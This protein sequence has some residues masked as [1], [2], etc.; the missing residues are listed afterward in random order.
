M[1]TVDI[2]TDIKHKKADTI[3]PLDEVEAL[4][5]TLE[6]MDFKAAMSSLNTDNP[7]PKDDIEWIDLYFIKNDK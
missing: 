4:I 2:Y 7:E 5:L 1:H 6:V 3:K